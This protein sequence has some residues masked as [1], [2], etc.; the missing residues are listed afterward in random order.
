[1]VQLEEQENLYI[2]QE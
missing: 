2:G 1:M